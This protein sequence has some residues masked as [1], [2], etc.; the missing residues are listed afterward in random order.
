MAVGV[1]ICIAALLALVMIRSYKNSHLFWPCGTMRQD[2]RNL[3]PNAYCNGQTVQSNFYQKQFVC[4]PTCDTTSMSQS[5]LWGYATP[6][7]EIQTSPYMSATFRKTNSNKKPVDGTSRVLLAENTAK[8]YR[9]SESHSLQAVDSI[10]SDQLNKRVL[11]YDQTPNQNY[12]TGSLVRMKG[13][14][15]EWISGPRNDRPFSLLHL[16][17]GLSLRPNA[18]P[19]MSLKLPRKRD[20]ISTVEQPL[21]VPLGRN[22]L[23]GT[24]STVQRMKEPIELINLKGAHAKESQISRY[25]PLDQSTLAEIFSAKNTFVPITLDEPQTT[26]E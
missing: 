13:I 22:T 6:N 12:R 15:P 24:T 21:Y 17:N 18:Q 19:Y 25:D 2:E 9:I 8:A 5:L 10:R 20:L 7:Q 16:K 11:I 26:P 4:A 23:L 3:S 14:S 1:L